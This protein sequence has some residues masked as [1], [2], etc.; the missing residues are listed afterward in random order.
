MGDKSGLTGRFYVQQAL[1]DRIESVLIMKVLSQDLRSI[2]T[3]FDD[4][5]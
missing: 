1:S 5:L 2:V 3:W 4:G